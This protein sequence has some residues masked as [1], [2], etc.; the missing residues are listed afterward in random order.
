MRLNESIHSVRGKEMKYTKLMI[1]MA[2]ICLTVTPF[3]SC[4]SSSTETGE[5]SEAEA[6]IIA[7]SQIT[8]AGIMNNFD[9]RDEV[10]VDEGENWRVYFPLKEALDELGGEPHVIVTKADGTIVEIYYTQ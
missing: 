10:T 2:V 7:K 4:S 1:G 5:I 3:M 9:D 8:D 6:I